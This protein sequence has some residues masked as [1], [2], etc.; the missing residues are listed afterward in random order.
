P[1]RVG[2]RQLRTIW[3]TQAAG[4]WVVE[5]IDQTRLP[6]EL[7]VM[8]L[9]D[10]AAV[11]RAI[12]DMHLRGAPLIGAA[13]AYGVALAMRDDPSD[14]ALDRATAALLATRPTAVNL[15]RA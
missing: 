5:I 6:H 11:C 3:V 9:A 7:V 2:G 1:M 12:R 13:A 8:P 10:L 14:Q 4:P 15:R